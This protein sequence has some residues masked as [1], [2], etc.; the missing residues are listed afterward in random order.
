MKVDTPSFVHIYGGDVLH[1]AGVSRF[2]Q[3][4][5]GD[6]SKPFVFLGSC[7]A[8]LL[9]TVF[10]PLLLWL[11]L[12]FVIEQPVSFLSAVRQL[13][14]VNAVKFQ[15]IL[16]KWP[17]LRQSIDRVSLLHTWYSVSIDL[18]NFGGFAEKRLSLKG[19]WR[20]LDMIR[21]MHLAI[22]PYMRGRKF[23]PLTKMPKGEGRGLES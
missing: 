7:T 9:V 6:A 14:V 5:H 11:H 23:L 17:S 2:F 15:S 20:G 13:F 1:A 19:T 18:K 8:E 16:W 10:V 22:N 4:I 21:K 12:F 3:V